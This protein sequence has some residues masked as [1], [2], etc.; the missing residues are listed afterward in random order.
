[1][2]PEDKDSG[3]KS[4]KLWFCAATSFSIV[5]SGLIIPAAV[6][7]EVVMGLISVC[8]IFV[9]GNAATKWITTRHLGKALVSTPTPGPVK[10]S[11]GK[12]DHVG[13]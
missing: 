3:I 12:N 13:E 8:G 5:V 6:L 7:S 4:R 10:S 9:G 1:M 11:K 2:K